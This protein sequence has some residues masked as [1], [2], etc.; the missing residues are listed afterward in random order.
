MLPPAS[1]SAR[2]ATAA[3]TPSEPSTPP[4]PGGDSHGGDAPGSPIVPDDE[5]AH[6]PPSLAVAERAATAAE[7]AIK[8]AALERELAELNATAAP[9][10]ADA[11]PAP[12]TP[13]PASAPGRESSKRRKPGT[14]LLYEL[15]SCEE[16]DVV[17]L[18]AMALL[19]AIINNRGTY[20]RILRDTN[21]QRPTIASQAGEYNHDV[22]AR[23]IGIVSFCTNFTNQARLITLSLACQLLQ[24][25]TMCPPEE[26]EDDPGAMLPPRCILNDEHR[27]LLRQANDLA[28]AQLAQMYE[29]HGSRG[30]DA[31]ERFL[32]IFEIEHSA[33]RTKVVKVP[34]IMSQSAI[35]LRPATEDVPGLDFDW[36][37]PGTAEERLR[38]SI[39]IWMISRKQWMM[40]SRQVETTLPLRQPPIAI[41][42]RDNLD[43]NNS[44]LIGC[45]VISRGKNKQLL[46]VRRFMMVDRWRLVLMEPST[47]NLGWG[48]VRF[49]ANLNHVVACPESHNTRALQVVIRQRSRGP[50][51]IKPTHT[52]MFSGRFVFDDHIRCV[53]ALQYLERGRSNLRTEKI[54]I[55]E[56]LMGIRAAPS[57]NPPAASPAK[58]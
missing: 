22:V 25:L 26:T 52:V 4:R 3:P 41:S 55:L 17:A 29:Q 28:I 9:A 50:G 56:V 44:D 5:T 58:R 14:V 35:L 13:A 42:V 21:L 10:A 38:R 43:L 54:E 15:M 45:N 2:L 30:A 40:I 49:L 8:L 51:G 46:Q 18:Q 12:P 7:Q 53:A 24:M 36:R 20:T 31:Q 47:T 1:P 27:M 39:Q 19:H 16:D 48:I 23:L 11:A 32:D 34:M 6:E 57:T 37:S 33:L